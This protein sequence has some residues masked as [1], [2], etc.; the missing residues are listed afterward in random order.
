MNDAKVGWRDG[1]SERGTLTILWSCLSTV[2]ACTWTILHLNIP[3]RL[4]GALTKTI[5]KAKW[6]IITVLFPGFIFSKAVC[7]L[8]MAVDDLYTIGLKDGLTWNAPFGRGLRF[9]RRVLHY[10]PKRQGKKRKSKRYSRPPERKVAI[11]PPT[12]TTNPQIPE[13]R[14]LTLTHSYFA[15]MGGSERYHTSGFPIPLTAHALANC[16]I[17][18]DH[19]PLPDLRLRKEDIEDKS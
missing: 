10:S 13:E 5:R 16:C 4:D 18:S 7:E 8:Q 3:S 2:I 6:T 11:S 1:P 9:L 19:D 15:N 17:G 14:V 12:N